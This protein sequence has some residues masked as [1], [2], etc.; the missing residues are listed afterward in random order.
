MVTTIQISE[1]L[2]IKLQEMKIFNKESYEEIIWN[3]IEDHLELSDK[4]KKN[5]LSSEKNIK[6]KEI[7]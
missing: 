1:E 3:L 6:N 4:T 5:I 2:Q 7:Y